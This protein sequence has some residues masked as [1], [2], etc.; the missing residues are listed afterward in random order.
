MVMQKEFKVN[1]SEKIMQSKFEKFNELKTTQIKF[2]KATEQQIMKAKFEKTVERYISDLNN[3]SLEESV[4][5]VK[6]SSFY[7]T[8]QEDPDFV[9]HYPASYWAKD[10][11]DEHRME[12]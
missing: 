3:I 5:L 8:L 11:I 12:F 1:M 6:D 4:K 10:I 2:D 7:D 9:L